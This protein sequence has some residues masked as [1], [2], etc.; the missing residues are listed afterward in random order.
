MNHANI[1]MKDEKKHFRGAFSSPM[2]S[3]KAGGI[4]IL[5]LFFE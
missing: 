1:W 2:E 5:P 4:L 3:G